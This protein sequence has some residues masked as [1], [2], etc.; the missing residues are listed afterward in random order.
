MTFASPSVFY[1]WSKEAP[2]HAKTGIKRIG[3]INV[4]PGRELAIGVSMFRRYLTQ[5]R[6]LPDLTQV[7]SVNFAM[8]SPGYRR[9]LH[10]AF[11][12]QDERW[13][14]D[15]VGSFMRKLVGHRMDSPMVLE[16]VIEFSLGQKARK[17]AEITEESRLVA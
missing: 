13:T 5:L 14:Y 2:K 4:Q 9:A 1:N 17:E 15:H 11:V 6:S 7:V 12:R 16:Q 8:M 3:F 10:D